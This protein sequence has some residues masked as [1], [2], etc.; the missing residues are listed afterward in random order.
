M[1]MRFCMLFC[2]YIMHLI[3]EQCFLIT[4]KSCRTAQCKLI[5]K[6]L[7]SEKVTEGLFSVLSTTF[8]EK[9]LEFS[10]LMLKLCLNIGYYFFKKLAWDILLEQKKIQAILPYLSGHIDVICSPIKKNL[11]WMWQT[12]LYQ[13]QLFCFCYVSINFKKF[14]AEVG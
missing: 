10:T 9:R 2:M 1:N 3:T 14:F 7:K 13:F 4:K 11:G 5:L 6:I 8:V 12:P